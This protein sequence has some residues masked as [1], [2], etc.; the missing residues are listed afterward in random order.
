MK[1]CVTATVLAVLIFAGCSPE[2][3]DGNQWLISAGRD[4]ITVSDAALMWNALSEQEKAVF[5]SSENPGV[6]FALALA[7]KA[8]FDMLLDSS[9]VLDDTLLVSTAASWARIESASAARRLLADE[10]TASVNPEDI[11]FY[12]KNQGVQ[13]WFHTDSSCAPVPLLITELPAELAVALEGLAAADSAVVPGY[14]WVTLDSVLIPQTQLPGESDSITA[15]IIGSGRERFQYLREYSVLMQENTFFVSDGFT[16]LTSLPEDSVVISCT[17]GEWTRSS[18]ESEVGFFQS[19]FPAVEANEYWKDML[20]EN[21]VMQSYYQNLLLDRFPQVADS[22][23]A[24]SENTRRRLAVESIVK[25]RMEQT[26]TV[27][28]ADLEEEYS[29][30]SEPLFTAE[31]RV[32]ATVSTDSAGLADFSNA[33]SAGGDIEAYP[34]LGG[35]ALPDNAEGITRPLMRSD[36]PGTIS[37]VLFGIPLADTASWSGPFE[38]ETGIFAGFRLVEVIPPRPVSVEEISPMLEESARRRLE[39]QALDTFIAELMERFEVTVNTSLL[40]ALP[41]DPGAW[42]SID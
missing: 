6:E 30:L 7:G 8:V 1:N 14:G 23:R 28:P 17:V 32:F 27:T 24:E 40:R 41:G 20:V 25:S 2:T 10:E 42:I 19:R 21:L 13:V 33:L 36:L 35:L 4:T 15:E 5:Y 16:D 39:A 9:G 12:R 26:V 34:G 11:E 37:E 18:L 3:S 29:L 31:K 22:I 38:M